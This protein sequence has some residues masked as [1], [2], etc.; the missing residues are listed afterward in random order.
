MGRFRA[1]KQKKMAETPTRYYCNYCQDE[2][3]A[4]SV[5]CCECTDFDLCLQCFSAG[6]ELGSHQRDHDYQIIDNALLACGDKEWSMTEEYLLLDAIET[7]GFGN[8]ADVAS[9]IGS[10]S[11]A[12]AREHYDSNYIHGNLGRA[13]VPEKP[14][15]KVQDHTGPEDGPLSPSLRATFSPV[16]M[17]LADQQELG[18]MPLRDDFEREHDN[19]AETLVSNLAVTNEDDDLDITLKLI[20]VEIYTSRL[21]E[22]QRRKKIA[23][24][25]GIITA[26]LSST[27]TKAKDQKD[28]KSAS[29]QAPKR[30]PSKEETELKEKMR[31]LAQF[32]TGKEQDE[33]FENLHEEKEIRARIKELIKYRRNGITKLEEISEYEE[34]KCKRDRRKEG[35]KKIVD[36]SKRSGVISAKKTEPKEEPKKD[37]R[38]IVED[39]FQAIKASPGFSYLSDREKRLCSSMKMKPARYITLKTVIIRDHLM[40]RQG[41]PCKTRYPSNLDKSH[42][43]RITNYLAKSG[44]IKVS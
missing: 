8:W 16:E 38:E 35:K 44:W 32:M 11:P 33:F 12:E 27:A 5:R 6:A 14:S 41:L 2:L 4:F 29:T 15:F 7:F 3:K 24:D 40:R 18:Y 17:T 21:K 22:R 10:K 13:A 9:H 31:A 34:A 20:H 23:R 37:D 43:K 25:F 36:K 26:A 28:Q 39:E 19:D 1:R 42:R 30:R